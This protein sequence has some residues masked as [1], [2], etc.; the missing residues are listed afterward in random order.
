MRKSI[1]IILCTAAILFG[2]GELE[3]SQ[4]QHTN[5]DH[6]S[7]KF[8]QQVITVQ[9]SKEAIARE[10]VLSSTK[11]RFPIQYIVDT[12]GLALH[13]ID[14]RRDLKTQDGNGRLEQ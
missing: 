10:L 11:T 8:G 7:E 12:E 13:R 6:V 1:V 9:T 5:M 2:C 3:E 4:A 14:G